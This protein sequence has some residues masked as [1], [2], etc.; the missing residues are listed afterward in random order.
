MEYMA[1]DGVL[2]SKW[3]GLK[4]FRIFTNSYYFFELL[5]NTLIYSVG[6]LLFSLLLSIILSITISEC[7]K[8]ALSKMVQTLAYLPNFLS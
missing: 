7:N 5:R 4:H 1:L 2:G 3:V 6:K 8:P